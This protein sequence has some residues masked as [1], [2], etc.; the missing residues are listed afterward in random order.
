MLKHV[1]NWRAWSPEPADLF[2]KVA[3]DQALHTSAFPRCISQQDRQCGDHSLGFNLGMSIHRSLHPSSGIMKSS[4]IV[5]FRLFPD[6]QACSAL[7]T[8]LKCGLDTRTKKEPKGKC[9]LS[10]Q[11]PTCKATLRANASC[12]GLPQLEPRR[13]WGFM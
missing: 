1:L 2:S 10:H 4:V 6:C 9:S 7:T 13:F 12:L 11:K 5:T 3:H 8:I